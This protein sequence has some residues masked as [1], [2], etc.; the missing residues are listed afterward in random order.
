[1]AMFAVRTDN[2]SDHLPMPTTEI[3]ARIALAL[4][5]AVPLILSGGQI[6]ATPRSEK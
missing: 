3:Y 2:L 1:M 5:I 4:S 6:S